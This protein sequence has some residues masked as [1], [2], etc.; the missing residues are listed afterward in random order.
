MFFSLA[1]MDGQGNDESN[2]LNLIE[3]YMK[4]RSAEYCRTEIDVELCSQC[5]SL[6]CE[7]TVIKI[8]LENI[9]YSSDGKIFLYPKEVKRSLNCN[10]DTNTP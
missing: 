8:P 4:V 9:T 3:Q 6:P 5:Y 2:I 7:C 10:C 1:N